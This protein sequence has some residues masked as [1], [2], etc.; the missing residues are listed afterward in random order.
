MPLS[1]RALRCGKRERSFLR[2]G[3]SLGIPDMAG[4]V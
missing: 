1:R 4:E 2:R 3:E